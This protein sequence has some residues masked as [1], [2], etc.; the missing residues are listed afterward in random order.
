MCT[1][2]WQIDVLGLNVSALYGWALLPQ[3]CRLLDQHMDAVAEELVNQVRLRCGYV[4]RLCSDL[5]FPWLRS[6]TGQVHHDQWMPLEAALMRLRS[7]PNCADDLATSPSAGSIGSSLSSS[8][9][10][11]VSVVTSTVDDCWLFLYPELLLDRAEDR[12]ARHRQS[13][14][15]VEQSPTVSAAQ[16]TRYADPNLHS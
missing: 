11:L 13:R 7:P 15:L 2:A 8:F 10:W 9:D 1:I 16:Y 5:I 12:Q 14:E 6:R 3:L 4:T